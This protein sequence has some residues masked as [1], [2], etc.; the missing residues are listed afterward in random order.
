MDVHICL[1]TMTALCLL[2][3][4]L[5]LRSPFI[6][7]VH[8]ELRLLTRS[9]RFFFLY[10]CSNEMYNITGVQTGQQNLPAHLW[11]AGYPATVFVGGGS[12][13][14]RASSRS[15]ACAG[16]MRTRQSKHSAV[17]IVRQMPL[18]LHVTPPAGF[19]VVVTL[20]SWSALDVTP[21]LSNV[22]EIA[23]PHYHLENIV[24]LSA[25]V[26]GST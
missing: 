2:W 1:T 23:P 6:S 16:L 9:W 24:S 17:I 18:A 21:P 7:A 10:S 20:L 5:L 13:G 19:A 25:Y 15:S 12:C 8:A 26:K 3:K 4:L 14:E 22:E 11:L